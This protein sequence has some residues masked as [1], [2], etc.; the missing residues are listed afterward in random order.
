MPAEDCSLAAENLM[1]AAHAMG[2]ATCP[3]GF[4]RLWLN[5]PDVKKELGIPES[6]APVFP[7]VVGFQKEPAHSVERKPP[8]ILFWK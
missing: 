7:V 5:R 3:I 6:Y 4:A 8:E 1:L 2:L